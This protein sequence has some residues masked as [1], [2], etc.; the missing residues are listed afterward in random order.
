MR[1]RGATL[2]LRCEMSA[3]ARVVLSA[4]AVLFDVMLAKSQHSVQASGAH[5]PHHVHQNLDPQ[6]YQQSCGDH[7]MRHRRQLGPSADPAQGGCLAVSGQHSQ[8]GTLRAQGDF[9][10]GIWH[11][12]E[13]PPLWPAPVACW[14]PWLESALLG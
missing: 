14:D 12:L 2:L 13:W 1:H 8:R 10:C 5:R 4:Q 11:F 6:R 9:G 3:F 7:Q